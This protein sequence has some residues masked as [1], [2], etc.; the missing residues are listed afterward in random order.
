MKFYKIIVAVI[1]I[2]L[3]FGTLELFAQTPPPGGTPAAAPLDT[4]SSILL[5][6]GAGYAARKLRAERNTSNDE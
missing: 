2:Q 3:V 5:V 6:A 1:T 4:F